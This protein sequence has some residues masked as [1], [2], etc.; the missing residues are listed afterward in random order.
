MTRD[1]G[2]KLTIHDHPYREIVVQNHNIRKRYTHAEYP[3]LGKDFD[4]TYGSLD[5]LAQVK[6]AFGDPRAG[7]HRTSDP[8]SLD[9][10][11]LYGEIWDYRS[12][13]DF[14]ELMGCL[15]IERHDIDPGFAY[16][17]TFTL[18]QDIFEIARQGTGVTAYRNRPL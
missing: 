12:L 2:E 1:S 13:E 5:I 9:H 14:L 6:E 8:T 3:W 16:K 7:W 4:D 18:S 11:H 15:A 10:L 17:V